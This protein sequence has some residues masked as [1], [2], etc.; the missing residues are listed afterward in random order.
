VNLGNFASQKYF[1]QRIQGDTN[2]VLPGFHFV[3][4]NSLTPISTLLG[5]CVS[6]CIYDTKANIGGLNHFLLPEQDKL[7]NACESSRYGVHAMEVLINDLLKSGARKINLAA[8]VFGGAKVIQSASSETV[9]TQNCE[10]VKSYLNSEKIPISAEDL[11]GEQARR[12][13]FFSDSGRVSVLRIPL[14]GN[15]ELRLKDIE[16]R[17]K[18]LEKHK[19]G[20][21]ELF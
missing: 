11:G 12:I 2:F 3:Q 19:N 1:D 16:M 13:Y 18:A 21:V 6:A 14:V 4:T 10:F 15:E 7:S 9:G 5:S 20:G 8:K 17:K